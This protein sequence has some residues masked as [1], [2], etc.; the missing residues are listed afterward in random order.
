MTILLDKRNT[1]WS[2]I[3]KMCK[4]LEPFNTDLNTLSTQ[5]TILGVIPMLVSGVRV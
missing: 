4:D 5:A 2:R 3:R 1:V